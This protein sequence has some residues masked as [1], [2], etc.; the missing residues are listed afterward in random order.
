MCQLRMLGIIVTNQDNILEDVK[1]RLNFKNAFC[2][3][4]Y[5]I[6]L[7]PTQTCKD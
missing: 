7:Y 2:R 5:F 3:L 4:E 1:S 6:I